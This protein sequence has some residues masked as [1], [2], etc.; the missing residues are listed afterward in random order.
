MLSITYQKPSEVEQP[1]K[2]FIICSSM[3]FNY[4]FSTY[5]KTWCKLLDKVC[6]FTT[7]CPSAL[8]LILE[9]VYI[10]TLN[11]RSIAWGQDVTVSNC[12]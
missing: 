6:L 11:G 5:F 8:D 4:K 10:L 9:E 12:V 7:L 1:T 2:L 3:V